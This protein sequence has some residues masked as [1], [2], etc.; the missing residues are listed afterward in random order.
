MV[1]VES[2]KR[3]ISNQYE[4]K[5]IQHGDE[6]Q[7]MKICMLIMQVRLSINWTDLLAGMGQATIIQKYTKGQVCHWCSSYISEHK[8]HQIK[9]RPPS[10]S[11]LFELQHVEGFWVMHS[12]LTKWISYEGKFIKTFTGTASWTKKQLNKALIMAYVSYNM[13]VTQPRGFKYSRNNWNLYLKKLTSWSV[14]T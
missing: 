12:L 7:A 3:R 1:L 5:V 11:P 8:P 10:H 14:N 13:N 9:S 4:E 2:L 6:K